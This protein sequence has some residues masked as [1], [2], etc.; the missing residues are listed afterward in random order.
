MYIFEFT[1]TLSQ[2]DLA[3]I[4]QK[5]TSMKLE[6]SFEEAEASVSH[7]LLANELMG[8]GTGDDT[9]PKG[10][11]LPNKLR[12]MVFK[13][14][15]RA[16]TNYFDKVVGVKGSPLTGQTISR[17][18]SLKV[19]Q[20]LISYNWPYDFFSLVELV[21]I[22][23]EVTFSDLESQDG[24][25]KNVPKGDSKREKSSRTIQ[26]NPTVESTRNNIG[27]RGR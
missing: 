2:Q 9:T 1:H 14:K 6:T 7:P 10:G 5:L 8:Y 24:T 20:D 25:T 18:E 16:N 13:V 27:R 23:A 3:D 22:D 21:K 15:Q 11:E 17:N 12:W 26:Q 4:W 19:D